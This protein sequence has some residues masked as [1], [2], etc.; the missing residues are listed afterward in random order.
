[1]KTFRLLIIAVAFLLCCQSLL[2]AQEKW[3][4]SSFQSDEGKELVITEKYVYIQDAGDED[5]I[6][7]GYSEN[8]EDISILWVF[9][10]DGGYD[11][12]TITLNTDGT[13]TYDT[14]DVKRLF[15]K[16]VRLKDRLLARVDRYVSEAEAAYWEE[17][18]AYAALI[19]SH[20]WLEGC[21]K[22]NETGAFYIITE[23]YLVYYYPGTA[24]YSNGMEVMKPGCTNYEEGGSVDIYPTY[25]IDDS[26]SRSEN[27]LSVNLKTKKVES[28]FG[29]VLTKFLQ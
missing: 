29:G 23:E 5:G 11:A 17:R 12:G 21:W 2:S 24:D 7:Y 9:Q 19:S 1:M 18:E 13:L 25:R 8:V 20:K 27:G 10:L 14:Y 28:Y 15:K 16:D 3:Y 26:S 4:M 6:L 22:N